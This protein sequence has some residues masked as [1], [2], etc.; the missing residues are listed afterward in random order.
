MLQDPFVEST[1]SPPPIPSEPV[2]ISEKGTD[3]TE[4]ADRELWR[5]YEH[6]RVY[7][8]R[9]LA[10][11]LQRMFCPCAGFLFNSLGGER[12]FLVSYLMHQPVNVYV[13]ADTLVQAPALCTHSSSY[14]KDGQD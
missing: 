10:D 4:E 2:P 6:E 11:G 8:I 7:R 1:A 3:R 12:N 14:R 13:I 5:R 9:H